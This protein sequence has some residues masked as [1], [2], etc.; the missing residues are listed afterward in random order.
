MQKQNERKFRIREIKP[1]KSV[2]CLCSIILVTVL[3]IAVFTGA[4]AAAIV[5]NPTA[6]VSEGAVSV[7]FDISG[8]PEEGLE[9]TLI[10]VRKTD[11][12]GEEPPT[13]MADVLDA[14]CSDAQMVANGENSFSI[15][16]DPSLQGAALRIYIIA[17]D[18]SAPVFVD[19]DGETVEEETAALANSNAVGVTLS[20][21][22]K[23][24]NP[25]E[26]TTIRLMNGEV[27]ESLIITDT[28]TGSGHSEQSFEFEDVAPGTYSL[29]ITKQ[30][31]TTF[32]VKNIIVSDENVDLTQSS[33]P[34]VKLIT[35]R[36]GDINED[37]MINDGD[38]TLLWRRGNFDKSI[39]DANNPLCDLN[40]DGMINDGDLTILWLVENYNKGA[41]VIDLTGSQPTNH[42]VTFV[43]WDGTTLDTQRIASGSDA[44]PPLLS[45]REG[46]L[47]T[48]W[49]GS[50]NNITT[51][52]ILTAVYVKQSDGMNIFS[53]TN[54]VGRP[55]D[56]VTLTV[57]LGGVVNTC[58]FDLRILYDGDV[59]EYVSHNEDWNLD[60]VAF[61]MAAEHMIRFNYSATRNR[62][63]TAKIMEISFR[64]K[65]ASVANTSVKLQPIEVIF[66]DL[67]ND[68]I[69]T[70]YEDGGY[71]MMDG[72]VTV[73][74]S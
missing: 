54:A 10:V 37:G 62:T 22:I 67:D 71:T 28:S 63:T 16:I 42:T 59:L 31:H 39:G 60:I 66:A 3:L 74:K 45:E 68:N 53:V 29:V 11:A 32:T 20:G 44:V 51:D 5:E 73:S 40:G 12:T 56:I 33:H 48:G 23:S 65:D 17:D 8:A 46:F 13:D 7:S 19:V 70:R 34:G 27:E 61:H 38:L 57:S 6:T 41:V 58:G 52:T 55:G 4:S 15:P 2:Y 14:V 18:G 25:K 35:L 9:A 64:I 69:P 49:D 30:A 1:S 43:D 24:F 21:C 72:T 26:P 50:Y 36:C 47:F